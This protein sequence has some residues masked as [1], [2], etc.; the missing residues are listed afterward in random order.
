MISE[1][2]VEKIEHLPL[3]QPK[4]DDAAEVE[5]SEKHMEEIKALPLSQPEPEA[6]TQYEYDDSAKDFLVG[7]R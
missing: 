7:F 2:L 1:K 4:F 3:S 6:Q 5:I